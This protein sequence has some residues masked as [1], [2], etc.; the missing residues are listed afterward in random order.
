MGMDNE[1]I[2]IELVADDVVYG[3]IKKE[4]IEKNA[5]VYDANPNYSMSQ[6]SIAGM[7]EVSKDLKEDTQ[8]YIRINGTDYKYF[9]NTQDDILTWH[10]GEIKHSCSSSE[11]ENDEGEKLIV[12][13]ITEEF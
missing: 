2:N 1:N 12:N 4:T 13:E 10:L 11:F 7:L 9:Y 5:L 8:Y 6:I 3:A